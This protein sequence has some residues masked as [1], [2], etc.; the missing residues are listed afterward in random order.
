MNPNTPA[1]KAV[2]L[3]SV[4]VPLILC[5]YSANVLAGSHNHKSGA[6]TC[7]VDKIKFTNKGDYL[8]EGVDLQFVSGTDHQKYP[9][10]TTTDKDVQNQLAKVLSKGQSLVVDLDKL[11]GIWIDQAD[12]PLR[13]EN[14]VW[15]KARIIAG[16]NKSCHKDNHKLVYRKGVGKTM[17]FKTGGQTLTNNRCKYNGNMDNDCYTGE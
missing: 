15:I 8:I 9:M 6:K 7:Y 12:F 16:E 13:E 5:I 17:K 10:L 4:L 2:K 14:E 1:K 11:N 3:S